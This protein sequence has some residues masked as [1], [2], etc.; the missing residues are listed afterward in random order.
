MGEDIEFSIRII[1]DTVST[2]AVLPDLRPCFLIG[3]SWGECSSEPSPQTNE[4]LQE[5][6]TRFQQLA[7]GQAFLP[8][9]GKVASSRQTRM[10]ALLMLGC[11]AC[12]AFPMT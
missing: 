6:L 7:V 2:F 12:L 3:E 9:G 5:N 10:P 4:V 11:D 1:G 8:A